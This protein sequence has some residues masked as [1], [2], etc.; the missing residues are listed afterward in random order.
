[1][2]EKRWLAL[3]VIGIAIIA[4]V[5]ALSIATTPQP[6]SN[7]SLKKFSSPQEIKAFLQ[8]NAAQDSQ[9]YG[10]PPFLSRNS[11]PASSDKSAAESVTSGN[12]LG[13]SPGAADHSTTNVQVA[14]V[15]EADFVK[16]DGKYIYEVSGGTLYIVEAYPPEDAKVIAKVAIAGSPGDLY[17]KGDRLLL[18]S[19]SYG[20]YASPAMEAD[21]MASGI[22]SAPYC[23]A[24]TRPSVEAKVYSIRDRSN[25]TLVQTYTVRGNYVASRMIDNYVYLVT[26]DG[27]WYYADQIT[28]PGVKSSTSAEIMPDVYYI[29]TPVQSYA[30]QTIAGINIDAADEI[31]AKSFLLDYTSTIFVSLNNLYIARTTWL[32][33]DPIIRPP[34]PVP[35]AGGEESSAAKAVDVVATVTASQKL[36]P[37]MVR[38]KTIVHKF[39][40]KQGE[41]THVAEGEV[42]GHPLNQFSMDESGGN[43]RITTTV[44][45]YTDRGTVQFNNLY[46]LNGA[47]KT[48]GRLEQIAP[49]ERIYSTRFIGDR[50]YMVTFRRIDP[51]FVI[52]LSTPETPK[53]LG[54]LKIPGYSDYLH[55]Y[56]Q[57]HII[58]IGKETSSNDWGGVS[59]RGVKLALFDVTDVANPVLLDQYEI[60]TSGADSEALQD[61]RAFLFDREKNLLVI[62]VRDVRT[63]K[64]VSGPYYEYQPPRIWQGAYVFGVTPSTGF[65]LK[66]TITHTEGTDDGYYY[67]SPAAVRRALYMGDVLYTI[68]S[69][70]I[71]AND[72]NDFEKIL[73]EV[74][75]SGSGYYYPV[76]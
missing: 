56:D 48:I 2:V 51:L 13:P 25:P 10:I 20:G 45:G 75:L 37:A 73:T 42:V 57:N 66:G 18:F 19:S 69:Q 70:K 29:D 3:V 28:V 8:R 64:V 62:P 16:N 59:I 53:V 11:V 49:G 33:D 24:C 15:D 17:I 47:M 34:M 12:I 1:M 74:T 71:L 46:V 30:Y 76:K 72:L 40:L 44:D 7:E 36:E 60:G 38:E 50:A 9:S 23:L 6:Q 54:E 21:R 39:S 67:S 4:G 26:S 22:S 58:C 35:M 14:G 55:P 52:D 61:H 41:A 63:V 65:T 31:H 5:V 27:A 43:F 68:S 32:Q